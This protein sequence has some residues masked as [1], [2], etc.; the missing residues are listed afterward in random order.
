MPSEYQFDLC[1]IRQADD[2]GFFHAEIERELRRL[3]DGE[4]KWA[5]DR[6]R[7]GELDIAV[8]EING[9]SAIG[10]EEEWMDAFEARALSDCWQW[11]NGYRL[12]VIP[13]ED[14]GCCRVKRQ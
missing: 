8:A 6:K 13:K 12:E 10:T 5:V 1:F 7:Q 9:L 14:A 4:A 2:T 11:L 3:F